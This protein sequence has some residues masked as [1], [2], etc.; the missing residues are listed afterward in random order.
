MELFAKT[1]PLIIFAKSSILD[2]SQASKYTPGIYA[3]SKQEG[4]LKVVDKDING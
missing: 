1:K 4:L 2:I 3:T